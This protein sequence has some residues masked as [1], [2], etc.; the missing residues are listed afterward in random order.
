MPVNLRYEP[1]YCFVS[2]ACK[3][4][5]NRVSRIMNRI[6]KQTIFFFELRNFPTGRSPKIAR[7][8]NR[9]QIN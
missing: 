8:S 1:V 5:F 2:R 7:N 9:T 3:L 4:V 6:L